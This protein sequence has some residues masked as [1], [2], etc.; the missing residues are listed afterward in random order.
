MKRKHFRFLDWGSFRTK[1]GFILLEVLLSLAIL[2]IIVIAYIQAVVAANQ[3]I[4][5]SGLRNDALRLAQSTMIIVRNM[6]DSNFNLLTTGA[7]GLSLS[8][9]KW[10]FSGVS[11]TQGIYT[12]SVT[13]SDQPNGTKN[14]V[15]TVSWPQQNG[16]KQVTVSTHIGRWENVFSQGDNVSWLI[17]SHTVVD[18]GD[19]RSSLQNIGIF[20]VGPIPLVIDKFYIDWEHSGNAERVLEEVWMGGVRVWDYVSQNN[21]L[22]L[23]SPA[24]LDISDITIYPGYNTYINRIDFNKNVMNHEITMKLIMKDGTESQVYFETLPNYN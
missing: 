8:G 24:L 19:G 10:N 13:I 16:T 3:S 1:K 7:H 9:G 14:V 22:K 12:R 15:T 5:A 6:R 21:N 2:G 11:D 23:F 18:L 4:I 20:N 17:D